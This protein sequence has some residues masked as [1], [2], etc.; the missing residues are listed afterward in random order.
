MVR[1]RTPGRFDAVCSGALA[2]FGRVGFARAQMADIAKEAGVSTGTLYNYVDSKEALLLHALERSVIDL[3]PPDDLPVTAPLWDEYLRRVRAG[4]RRAVRLHTL[5]AALATNE[6]P[7][8]I[9]AELRA[10][11]EELYDL[12]AR[13]RRGAIALERSAVDVPALAELYFGGARRDLFVHL[14]AYL[15]RRI[16]QGL[17]PAVPDLAA[18]VRFVA[19]STTWFA[20]HRQGDPGPSDFTDEAARENTV[21]LLLR[22]LLSAH[23]SP[24]HPE[25]RP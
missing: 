12:I 13:T 20:R 25:E 23:P 21:E 14:G 22:A 18:T 15:D 3:P 17:L 5:E 8:T 10:V 16:D 6:A 9:E 19:E 24:P 11:L 7:T 4:L 1:V 2:V